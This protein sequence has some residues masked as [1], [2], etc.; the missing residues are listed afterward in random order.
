M[1]RV[2]QFE[3]YARPHLLSIERVYQVVRR[4]LPEDVQVEVWRARRE[5][6][7]LWARLADAWAARSAQGEVNHVTGDAHYLTWFLDP[8]RTVLTIHDTVSLDRMRGLKRWVFRFLWY[9]VP[10][11]RCAAVVTI[12]EAARECLARHVSLRHTK[13][14]TI[15]N[16]A[17]ALADQSAPQHPQESDAGSRPLVLHIGT[18]ANKNLDRHVAALAGLDVRLL[19]VGRLTAE[20]HGLLERSKLEYE[21]RF[22]LSDEELAAAYRSADVLQFTSLAEGF[23]LPVVEAQVA[24][25]PVVTSNCSSLPEVAGEGALLVDPRDVSAIRAA[26]RAVLSEP[27]LRRRLIASGRSNAARFEPAMV[28]QRYADLYRRVAAEAGISR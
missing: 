2:V 11:R 27:D 13:V 17:E 7:S 28:A 14:L 21:N 19:V 5:P 10:V 9:Q 24:G 18:K 8:R 12:S 15:P 3:R 16:P 1:V 26:V 20:Q 4:H 25:V 23:G 6:R 22:N